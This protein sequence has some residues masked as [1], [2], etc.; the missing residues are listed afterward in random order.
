MKHTSDVKEKKKIEDL[1]NAI[2]D[3]NKV[4][5]LYYLFF[6]MLNIPLIVYQ[7]A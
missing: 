5:P 1:F 3:V 7:S 2:A 6:S 4:R